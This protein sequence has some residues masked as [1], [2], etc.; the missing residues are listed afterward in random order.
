MVWSN[1][2]NG[3]IRFFRWLQKNKNLIER[4]AYNIMPKLIDTLTQQRREST[5]YYRLSGNKQIEKF[6]DIIYQD[7]TRYMERKFLKF[8]LLLK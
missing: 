7:A 6:Y 4:K 2:F 8:Q 3:S 1:P 5:W